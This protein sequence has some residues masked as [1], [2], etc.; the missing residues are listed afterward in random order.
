MSTIGR[1]LSIAARRGAQAE[2]ASSSVS[3]KRAIN[4]PFR[5]SIT[6]RPPAPA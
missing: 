2:T 3:P 1:R 4:V 5:A 6:L